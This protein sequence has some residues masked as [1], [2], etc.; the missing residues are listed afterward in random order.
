V[1]GF[2]I[3][4]GRPLQSDENIVNGPA[5]ACIMVCEHLTGLEQELL[6]MGIKEVHR[7][8]PWS[9]NCR[10]WVYFD[11]CLDLVALRARLDLAPSIIDHI[12]RGTHDGSEA[13]LVCTRCWDAI[14]GAHPDNAANLRTFG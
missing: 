9:K 12:H 13:G 7:G 4:N 10:E 14:M 5:N 1:A 6:R 8:Q 11:C 3:Y 2:P